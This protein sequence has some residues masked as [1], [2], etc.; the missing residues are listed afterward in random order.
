M[1]VL[2]TGGAGYIGSITNWLLRKQGFET[3]VFD[4]LS[5]GHKEAVGETPLVVGDLTKKADV[6]SLFEHHQFDAVVHFAAL[7][8]AGES[9]ERPADYYF[10]NIVGGINLLEA[11]K[12][13]GCKHIVFSSTCALY[14]TPKQLPVAEAAPINPE[15]VY[16]SSKRMVEEILAWYGKL[17]D[18]RYTNL[19]YF[20][21]SGALLDGSLGEDHDPETHLI[22]I[23]LSV[24]AG[25]QK[26]LLM[27]GDDYDTPDGTCIRDYI[28]VLDLADAHVKALE[29][30]TKGGKSDS[31]NLGVGKGYSNKE[32]LDAVEQAVGK[33]IPK[34]IVGRRAGDPA[35]IWADNTK[36]KKVLGWE[37]KYSD[38]KT[39]VGSA[40]RWYQNREAV[41]VTKRVS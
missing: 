8:L 22:P 29:Y 35:A 31:F 15:S 14:G 10:N 24:A 4:N 33:E 41:T 39:I 23:A 21:A 3:V 17:Y 30:L 9:M 1:K 38:L 12:T 34:K 32:V 18:I 19:R 40:W 6:S 20:N 26:E 13:V 11:M 27:N 25:K 16:A 36:A 5:C 2:V 7:A 28:H 37:P